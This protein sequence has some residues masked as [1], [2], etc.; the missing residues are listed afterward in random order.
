MKLP[1]QEIFSLQKALDIK[2]LE[3]KK[4]IESAVINQKFLALLVELGEFS[5]ELRC[6][7]YWSNNNNYKSRSL[8]LEEYI[9]CLHFLVSIALSFN[10]D[11]EKFQFKLQPETDL[12]LLLLATH[13]AVI[14]FWKKT[15]SDF[16]V[17]LNNF[18]T[19]GTVIGFSFTEVYETYLYKNS[20][21]HQRIIKNY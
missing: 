13:D 19:I 17:I 18:L 8:A 2:I 20:I 15:T 3:N 11:I 9:D 21:N 6:F 5:N 12:N 16:T 10:I 4:L 7:K 14:T 1:W